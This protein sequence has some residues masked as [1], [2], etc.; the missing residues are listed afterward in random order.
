MI[1]HN[2]YNYTSDL[3]NTLPSSNGNGTIGRVFFCVV[4]SCVDITAD[5]N[6]CSKE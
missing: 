1:L 6:K 4:N 2:M 5:Y 3:E